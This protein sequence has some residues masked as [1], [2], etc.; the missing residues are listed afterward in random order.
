V[1]DRGH[2]YHLV[3]DA[4]VKVTGLLPRALLRNN[5]TWSKELTYEPA[6]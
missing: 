1:I 4:L 5:P 6:A 2:P 3:A